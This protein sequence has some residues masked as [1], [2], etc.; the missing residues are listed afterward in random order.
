M[1]QACKPSALYQHIPM[2]CMY[3]CNAPPLWI[4]AVVVIVHVIMAKHATRGHL[5]GVEGAATEYARRWVHHGWA[6]GVEAILRGVHGGLEARY[7]RAYSLKA[8]APSRGSAGAGSFC[9]SFLRCGGRRGLVLSVV[10]HCRRAHGQGRT[11]D[12]RRLV[13]YAISSRR[14]TEAGEAESLFGELQCGCRGASWMLSLSC[15]RK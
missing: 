8:I 13:D 6:G 1:S 9:M 3:P 15:R 14:S 7:G 11:G 4:S 12:C 10:K 2:A 5:R